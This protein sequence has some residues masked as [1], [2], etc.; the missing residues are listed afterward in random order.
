MPRRET[1]LTLTPHRHRRR[2]WGRPLLLVV[3]TLLAAAA[4]WAG[5]LGVLWLYAWVALGP[6]AVPVLDDPPAEALGPS[7]AVAPVDATTVLVLLTAGRDPTVRQEPP[8]IADPV[9]VQLG[10]GRERPAVLSLPRSLPVSV[11]GAGPATLEQAQLEGGMDLSVRTVEDHTGVRIDHVVSVTEDALPALVEVLEPVERCDDVGCRPTDPD[12][13]R[14]T[15]L[16]AQ[17][18]ERHL[19]QVAALVQA[20]AARIEPARVVLA[21]WTAKQVVDVVAAEVRTDVE[22]RG[23]RLLALAQAL[24]EPTALDRASVPVLENPATGEVLLLAEATQVRFQH[25]QTGA[26]FDGRDAADEEADLR[27]QIEVVVLN[28][29]G[30]DGLAG[31]V[32]GDLLARG[33]AVVDTG[34]APSFGREATS[35]VFLADDDPIVALTAARLAQAIPGARLEPASV[36][37][38]HEGTVVPLLVILG[39]GAA[40]G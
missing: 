35:I 2:S 17:D 5:V 7:G 10:A 34:N 37:P 25:L 36:P 19:E 8:L 3:A 30:V 24:A 12:D 1:T 16:A 28:G 21:P 23:A 20:V 40:D 6:T 14:A 22:L 33:F 38:E 18:A 27:A 4:L 39:A 9:L 13:T 31:R 11:E 29:A 32:A 26:P 15:V